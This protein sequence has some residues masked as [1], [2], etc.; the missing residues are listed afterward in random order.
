MGLQAHYEIDTTTTQQHERFE[1]LK[2]HNTQ[3]GLQDQLK[4]HNTLMGLRDS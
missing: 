1:Q 3:M 2:G 4:G